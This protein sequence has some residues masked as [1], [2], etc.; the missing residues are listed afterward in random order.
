[1]ATRY[2]FRHALY[3]QVVYERLGAGRRVRLHQRLGEC[4][5]AAYGAQAGE[6][7]A[8]LAEHFARGYDARRAVHYLH[9]AAEKAT[10]RYAP[11][12]S[13]HPAELGP[14]RSSG[15]SQRRP[16]APSTNSIFR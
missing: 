1:M 6:I 5:E 10:Q 8:E 12:R 4:L 11:S 2:A 13:H 15:A 9:Q 3:Q 14:W 16:N 7:A